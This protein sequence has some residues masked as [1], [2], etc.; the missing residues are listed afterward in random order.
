MPDFPKPGI[1][2]KDITPLLQDAE[3]LR[4]S[5]EGLAQTFDPDS[6]DI[7]CGIESRGFI[8]GTAL[9][10]RLNK[11]FIPIRKPGKLPWKT[12]SQSYELEYGSDT[13]EIHT[14][15]VSKGTRVLMVDDLLATGGTMEAALKLVRR[16]GGDPVG[17]A[18]VIELDSLS[19]RERLGDIPVQALLNV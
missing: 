11:G 13:I 1:V 17:C 9:A 16:I 10:D 5:I 12:A 18:F 4:L 3:G 7:I 6:Y 2:F 19:G 14:D 15:A 8:F